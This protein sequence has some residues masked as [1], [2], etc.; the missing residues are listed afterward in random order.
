[1]IIIITITTRCVTHVEGVEGITSSVP[2]SRECSCPVHSRR[3]QEE[4]QIL[5]NTSLNRCMTFFLLVN[6]SPTVSCCVYNSHTVKF[7]HSSDHI[8]HY[9]K[10]LYYVTRTKH[11]CISVRCVFSWNTSVTRRKHMTIDFPQPKLLLKIHCSSSVSISA[12]I[13]K[14]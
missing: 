14:L 9:R 1:M 8:E 12:R 3:R 10:Q 4:T 6:W 11:D 2:Y 7:T 13:C 5:L